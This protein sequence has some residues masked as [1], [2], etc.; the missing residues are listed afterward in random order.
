MLVATA[1][2]TLARNVSVNACYF[3]RHVL[4]P[5]H[6][7]VRTGWAWALGRLD[8]ASGVGSGN[9]IK[10]QLLKCVRTVYRWW[11]CEVFSS[12]LALTEV[13]YR[14]SLVSHVKMLLY[15]NYYALG[16]R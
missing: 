1:S 8:W 12:G 2:D 13:H 5:L 7:D 14:Y 4:Y 6:E 9:Q 11:E 10:I 15:A 16:R 3:A